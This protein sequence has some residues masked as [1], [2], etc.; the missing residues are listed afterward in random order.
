[1]ISRNIP[2]RGNDA[3]LKVSG[4]RVLLGNSPLYLTG[5]NLG[6]WLMPE[7]Y[8]LHA[9]NRGVRFFREQFIRQRGA[10]ELTALERS[11]R[12]NFIQED[13]FSRIKGL[14][15]NS[16]RLPFHYGLIETKPYQY[17]KEGV[18]YLDHAIRWAKAQ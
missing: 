5:L 17:S 4:R 15:V 18:R 3:F 6:G 16:I 12:D 7:G 9:P 8:I 11:F 14:G 13:D 2:R 10:A 1:M